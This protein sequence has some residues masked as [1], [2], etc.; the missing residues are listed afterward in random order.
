[1]KNQCVVGSSSSNDRVYMSIQITKD[2]FDRLVDS[3]KIMWDKLL[4]GDECGPLNFLREILHEAEKM[5]D[6]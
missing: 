6:E 5:C 3:Y 4:P 2:Q 1:M